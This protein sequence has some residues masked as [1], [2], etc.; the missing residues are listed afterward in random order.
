MSKELQAK[1]DAA[2]IP[3]QKVLQEI[4]YEIDN[5]IEIPNYKKVCSCGTTIYGT[6]Q[7][8]LNTLLTIHKKDGEIH[9]LWEGR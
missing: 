4:L 2:C 8:E 7:K 6:S 3:L 5:D 9:K 1:L